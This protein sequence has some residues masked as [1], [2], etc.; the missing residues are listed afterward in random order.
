MP[1]GSNSAPNVA[2]EEDNIGCVYALLF[3]LLSGRNTSVHD[4]KA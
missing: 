4:L 1:S 2:M 3:L